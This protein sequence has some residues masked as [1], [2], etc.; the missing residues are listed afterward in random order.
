MLCL[1]FLWVGCVVLHVMECWLR[2][3]MQLHLAGS[4]ARDGS[5]KASFLLHMAFLSIWPV[6]IQEPSPRIL[7]VSWIPRKQKWKLTDLIRSKSGSDAMLEPIGHLCLSLSNYMLCGITL[8]A[9]NQSCW[10]YLYHMLSY[11]VVSKYLQPF[12]PQLT[13]LL[14]SQDFWGRHT[15]VCCHF[16]YRGSSWPKD[17]T[18][19]S[20]V[21]CISGGFLEIGKCSKSGLLIIFQK[22]ESHTASHPSHSVSSSE[23]Q[24]QPR[25]PV[26][27]ET[28]FTSW[29]EEWPR[30]CDHI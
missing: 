12:G 24:I 26:E 5:P 14:C 25:V 2:P 30:I 9:R 10:Q 18:Y 13:R 6:I 27:E 1:T 7:Q 16:L 29:S 21:F 4:P 11:S 19:V 20:C 22:A 15:G 17:Q 23:S 8:V 3:C 28:N